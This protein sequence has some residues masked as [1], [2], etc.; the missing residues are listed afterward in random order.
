MPSEEQV[1]EKHSLGIKNVAKYERWLPE[2]LNLILCCMFYD[3]NSHSKV[4]AAGEDNFVMQG[5][6]YILK[7]A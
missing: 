2:V 3:S 5:P 1:I 7:G 6:L 4:L